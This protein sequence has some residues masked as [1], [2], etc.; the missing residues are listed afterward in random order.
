[1]D[2]KCRLC[3][4]EPKYIGDRYDEY[5]STIDLGSGCGGWTSLRGGKDGQGKTIIIA[6]G[7]D[8][9]YYYPKFCPECGRKLHD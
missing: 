4:I 3:S 6:K 8:E 5:E 1:M 9:E 7:D 2:K